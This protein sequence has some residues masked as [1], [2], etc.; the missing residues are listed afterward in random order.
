MDAS[1]PPCPAWRQD[2][3]DQDKS[4]QDQEYQEKSEHVKRIIPD[5]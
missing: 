3:A 5:R 4:V 2:N 1:P